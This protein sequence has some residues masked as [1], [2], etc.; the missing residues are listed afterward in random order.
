MRGK[1]TLN[2]ELYRINQIM[3][4]SSSNI[5]SEQVEAKIINKV[6]DD[7]ITPQGLVKIMDDLG[8]ET[9]GVI[10]S[11]LNKFDDLIIFA[12]GKDEWNEIIQKGTEIKTITRYFNELGEELGKDSATIATKQ[13]EKIAIETD[14]Y[15][16]VPNQP[17]QLIDEKTYREI[18]ENNT[19]YYS[20]PPFLRLPTNELESYFKQVTNGSIST[21]EEF[22]RSLQSFLKGG[23]LTDGLKKAIIALM[24]ANPQFTK[25]IKKALMSSSDFTKRVKYAQ[26]KDTI[27]ELIETVADTLGLEK[28]S[29]LINDLGILLSKEGE[30]LEKYFSFL[31]KAVD[32]MKV[33]R[34]IKYGNV[35]G[36]KQ[37]FKVITGEILLSGFYNYVMGGAVLKGLYNYVT[38]IFNRNIKTKDKVWDSAYA[39]MIGMGIFGT[40]RSIRDKDIAQL[41]PVQWFMSVIESFS[42][43]VGTDKVSD[44]LTGKL[45]RNVIGTPQE[46][47]KSSTVVTCNDVEFSR[48]FLK[49]YSIQDENTVKMLAE[50]LYATLNNNAAGG[51]WWTILGDD[52]VDYTVGEYKFELGVP[53][54]TKVILDMAGTFR[55]DEEVVEN[56]LDKDATDILKM[57]QISD[58]YETNFN[59]SLYDD[60]QNMNQWAALFK[61]ATWDDIKTKINKLPYLDPDTSDVNY[62][63][64]MEIVEENKKYL[65]K[66]PQSI[67]YDDGD[68]E[69]TIPLAKCGTG[70]KSGSDDCNCNDGGCKIGGT[71]VSKDVGIAL[72]NAGVKTNSDF[73]EYCKG[74]DGFD[75]L[76][77]I[78]DTAAAAGGGDDNCKLRPGQ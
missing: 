43:C 69:V 27:D 72:N 49:R 51:N 6:L 25:I 66:Y 26:Y 39:I 14:Y 5:L 19:E 3:V 17:D 34:N 64:W 12:K 77:K 32:P 23:P 30:S 11:F 29:R 46:A 44:A 56:I 65:L 24:G 37:W 2:E 67:K 33:F 75:N 59:A 7:A 20:I 45:Y 61:G 35:V 71:L 62:D 1:K 68:F 70:C 18:V 16:V 55:P 36:N 8:F 78:Y 10:P 4:N 31:T 54:I 47:D 9:D 53:S 50:A 48:A 13:G 57:S 41:S 21:V 74:K 73:V 22:M 76:K 58:Y 60:M 28:T 52:E 40:Y 63:T 15:R 42:N 38:K